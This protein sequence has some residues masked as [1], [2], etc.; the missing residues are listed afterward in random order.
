VAGSPPLGSRE[1]VADAGYEPRFRPPP[2]KDVVA[3]ELTDAEEGV[4]V[5]LCATGVY[6]TT[7]AEAVRASFM[8]WCNA[9]HTQTR[10]ALLQFAKR[11]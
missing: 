4:L 9:N 8:R 2:A 10:R 3:I 7:V 1:L 11:S 6:G 5:G